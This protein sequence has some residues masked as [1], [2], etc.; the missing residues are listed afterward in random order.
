MLQIQVKYNKQITGVTVHAMT[1]LKTIFDDIKSKTNFE[2]ESDDFLFVYNLHPH[3]VDQTPIGGIQIDP[4]K[5]LFILIEKDSYTILNHYLTNI[6]PS[7]VCE[8]AAFVPQAQSIV[9]MIASSQQFIYSFSQD[10]VQSAV[11]SV[12]PFERLENLEGDAEVAEITKWFKEDFMT[13][14]KSV[15]CHH[16]GKET[17][18]AAVSL[19]V[20][21][22]EYLHQAYNVQIYH[23]N[24]CGANT[25]FPRYNDVAK[26][27][28][29]RTGRCG[30]FANT[31]AAV[32]KALGF[33]VRL[34]N[35]TNDHVWVEY[36]SE[37]KQRYVHVDPCEN[38][39]DKPYTY[40]KGWQK[41]IEW[42]F[43]VGEHQVQDVTKK[44]TQNIQDC[45]ARRKLKCTDEWYYKYI[46]FKNEVSLARA[47]P[48]IQEEVI[49]RQK[50]DAESMEVVRQETETEEERPRI[51]G[52]E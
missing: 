38:I 26:L 17:Q 32:L 47:D 6:A 33:D 9:S 31:F 15:K 11:L 48:E 13:F 49:D 29:T 16:C 5:N 30:E 35:D 43:A 52:N 3:P 50:K 20:T 34:V 36:W 2:G 22:D 42:V 23:C 51:S 24:S 10:E 7:L 41:K 18:P 45:I 8:A 4:A 46:R 14:T 44:Y 1:P 37:E 39:I 25:R 28:E 40:E 12:L 27:I 19:S 21:Q